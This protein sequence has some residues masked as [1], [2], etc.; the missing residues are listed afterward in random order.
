MRRPSLALL[1]SFLLVL[2]QHG[3]LLHEL[4]HLTPGSHEAGQALRAE[5]QP[6]SPAACAS[7][8]AYAQ[9]ANPAA[10]S[11]PIAPVGR[12]GYL[13]TAAPPFTIL[14][15]DSPTPRNRGPPHA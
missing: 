14:L 9:L 15:A 12:Q 11:A 4:G 1:L 13:T 7:C 6:G 10:G 2:V 8:E 3:A 5:L